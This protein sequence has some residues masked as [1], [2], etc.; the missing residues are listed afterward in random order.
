M[1]LVSKQET[2][3]VTVVAVGIFACQ[4]QVASKGSVNAHKARSVVVDLASTCKAIRVT[5]VLAVRLVG[6]G[7]VVLRA[8]VRLVVVQTIQTFAWI[9]VLI[10]SETTKTVVL[11]ARFV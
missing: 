2:I 7:S 4:G 6:S 11:V 8:L 10:S 3:L 9:D 1:E 5:V